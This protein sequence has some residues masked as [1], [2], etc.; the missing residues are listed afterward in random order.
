MNA[1]NRILFLIGISVRHFA[2][3]VLLLHQPLN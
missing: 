2:L 1:R 3:L